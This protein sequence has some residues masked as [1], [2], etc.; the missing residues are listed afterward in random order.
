MGIGAEKRFTG[1]PSRFVFENSFCSS[2]SSLIIHLL[3][4]TYNGGNYYTYIFTYDVSA[5]QLTYIP[6]NTIPDTVHILPSIMLS[7]S[8]YIVA[9][10]D[11]AP[12]NHAY[13]FSNAA[14]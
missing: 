5:L 9:G 7:A 4:W 13:L 12:H 10:W 6:L 14:S 8:L 11:T 3:G 1:F 2:P